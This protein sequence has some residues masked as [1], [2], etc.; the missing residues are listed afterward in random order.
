MSRKDIFL[1][2]FFCFSVVFVDGSSPKSDIAQPLSP[3]FKPLTRHRSMP[4]PVPA[5]NSNGYKKR[6]LSVA[7]IDE[8]MRLYKEISDLIFKKTP[9]PDKDTQTDP[10][11]LRQ[12]ESSPFFLM[13]DDE[14]SST[15]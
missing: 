15:K 12:E 2:L 14:S 5:P 4:I 3:Q 6:S 8:A 1:F 7:E 13:D 9:R 10:N 11:S